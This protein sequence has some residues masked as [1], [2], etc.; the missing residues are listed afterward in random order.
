VRN[1][2]GPSFLLP[3]ALETAGDETLLSELIDIALDQGPKYLEAAL[4]AQDRG[5]ASGVE[6]A[7]HKLRGA[8]SL[9]G[10][11]L[12]CAAL[13]EVE[14]AARSGELAESSTLLGVAGSEW[15]RLA[16]EL[17]DWRTQTGRQD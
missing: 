7:V 11:T 17:V 2:A 5:D 9:F 6:Y 4:S 10:A 15:R 16:D 1:V 3:S 13:E 14:R 12:L 8:V